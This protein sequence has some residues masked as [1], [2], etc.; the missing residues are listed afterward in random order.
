MLT[1]RWQCDLIDKSESP[2]KNDDHRLVLVCIDVFKT[3]KEA[4]ENAEA[5]LR[6]RRVARGSR[7]VTDK[8]HMEVNTDTGAEFKTPFP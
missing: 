7:A 4:A 6:I 5:F 3:R 2:E 1:E 8:S